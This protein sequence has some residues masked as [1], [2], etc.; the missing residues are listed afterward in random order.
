MRNNSTLAFIET[1]ETLHNL[2]FDG[3]N[4]AGIRLSLSDNTFSST[5][6][7]YSEKTN[8]IGLRSTAGRYGGTYA[9]EDITLNF[10]Y[11]LSPIFQVYFI[12]EFRRME[13]ARIIRKHD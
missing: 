1:W 9:H 2:D 10:C 8:A 11:W 3:E 5:P 6:Q 7:M 12:K 4:S 13:K